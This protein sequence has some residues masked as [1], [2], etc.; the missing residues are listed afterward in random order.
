MTIR[1]SPAEISTS[2]GGLKIVSPLCVR[3]ASTITPDLRNSD[4]CPRDC[5]V[6]SPLEATQTCSIVIF[7]PI[8]LLAKSR[9]STTWGRSNASAKLASRHWVR[10]EDSVGSCAA[11]LLSSFLLRD[12]RHNRQPWIQSLRRENDEEILRI[13]GQSR[14]LIPSLSGHPPAEDCRPVWHPRRWQAFPAVARCPFSFQHQRNAHHK[15]PSFRP[16]LLTASSGAAQ[17]RNP[18]LYLHR[19]PT[20]TVALL[21]E[22][23]SGP[24]QHPKATVLKPSLKGK[25]PG[26]A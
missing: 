8:L 2:A 20:H 14:N 19:S 13:R 7:D 17:Q 3:I 10:S 21:L 23:G 16:K 11:Q 1:K 22:K 4:G 26:L 5:L 15:K 18:L 12:S 25:R 9:N 24:P 6:R